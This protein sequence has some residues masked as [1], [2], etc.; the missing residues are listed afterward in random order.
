MRSRFD[1]PG[2]S[3]PNGVKSGTDDGRVEAG[4]TRQ[5]INFTNDGKE[6]DMVI[7]LRSS[8]RLFDSC[9]PSRNWLHLHLQHFIPVHNLFYCT[10]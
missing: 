7:A 5:A 6:G 4:E 9:H 2:R 10:I 3:E 1:G 8:T